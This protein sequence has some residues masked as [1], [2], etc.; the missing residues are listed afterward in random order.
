MGKTITSPVKGWE[1]TIV[2]HDPLTLPQAIVWEEA[3]EETRLMILDA[4]K[5]EGHESL[6]EGIEKGFRYSIRKH[7]QALWPAMRGC[8]EDWKI[9]AFELPDDN[10]FPASPKTRS[11]DF[12]NWLYD[13]IRMLFDEP[14]EIKNE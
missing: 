3:V 10:T 9:G 2:L 11:D 5:K 12:L 6:E 4:Y 1:G 8:I 7:N 14:E 13:E